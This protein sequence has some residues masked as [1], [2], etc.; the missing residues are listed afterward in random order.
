MQVAGLPC[1]IITRIGLEQGDH[2]T[3]H[4][5][6]FAVVVFAYSWVCQVKIRTSSLGYLRTLVCPACKHHID[7][8]ATPTTPTTQIPSI[9]S[10]NINTENHQT[11][12]KLDLL[13]EQEAEQFKAIKPIRVAEMVPPTLIDIISYFKYNRVGR[14]KKISLMD[15]VP[16]IKM[17]GETVTKLTKGRSQL[18]ATTLAYIYQRE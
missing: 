14:E 5:C 18:S 9:P 1:D 7:K 2:T 16:K 15:A 4:Y 11:R 6:G 12:I 10:I 3:C 8:E 17:P 13:Q